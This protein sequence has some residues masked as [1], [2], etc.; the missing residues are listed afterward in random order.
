MGSQPWRVFLLFTFFTSGAATMS[1]Q[2]TPDDWEVR[3]IGNSLFIETNAP[4]FI[5]DMQLEACLDEAEKDEIHANARLIAA[6]PELLEGCRAA[7]RL[8]SL[9][10]RI[11]S[12]KGQ[13]DLMECQ[14]I[15]RG[16]IA[17]ATGETP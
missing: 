14:D 2:H 3:K 4:K 9:M 10:T 13:M 17:K 6:A 11:T 16:A 12:K 15:I 1:T 7:L 5:C 8:P